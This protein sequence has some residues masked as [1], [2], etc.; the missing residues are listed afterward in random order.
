MANKK[1]RKNRKA[2][3]PRTVTPQIP[4]TPLTPA[5]YPG[6]RLGVVGLI[7]GCLLG[8]VGVIVSLIALVLSLKSGN[9]N[10]AAV[11]GIVIGTLATAVLVAGTF[12]MVGVLDGNVGVCAELGPG[13]HTQ[14]LMTYTCRGGE[15]AH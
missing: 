5:P 1:S 12:Y 6:Q 7:L 10:T 13:P 2:A 9:R 11:V 4:S 15:D 8:I 3:P 14:G